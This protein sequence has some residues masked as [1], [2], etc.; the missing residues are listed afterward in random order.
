M[1]WQG[2]VDQTLIGSGKIDKAAVEQNQVQALI[3]GYIDPRFLSEGFYIE[4][5]RYLAIK[6]D[7]RSIYGRSGKQGV[8]VAKTNEAIVIA[9]Y[10]ETV[11][12]E[13]ATNVTESLVN[14]LI[15]AG[16]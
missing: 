8:I 4:E 12:P 5:H 2:Y 16:Y 7:D 13:E 11:Q 9:H 1:S 14:Y 3:K 10:S 6:V 15:S